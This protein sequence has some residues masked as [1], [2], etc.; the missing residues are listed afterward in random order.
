MEVCSGEKIQ[1]LSNCENFDM[2]SEV[3]DQTTVTPAAESAAINHLQITSSV[4]RLLVVKYA[5]V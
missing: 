4:S 2:K 1:L 5:C 3:Q